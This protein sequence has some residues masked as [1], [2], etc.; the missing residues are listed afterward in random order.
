M[1]LWGECAAALQ[2]QG[3]AEV[4]GTNKVNAWDDRK[5]S[6]LCSTA[7]DWICIVCNLYHEITITLMWTHIF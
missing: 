3:L 1:T 2:T 4:S 7:I 6:L 5:E